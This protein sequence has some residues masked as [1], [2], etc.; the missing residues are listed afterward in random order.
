LDSPRFQPWGQNLEATKGFFI[1]EDWIAQG[2]NLR[3]RILE[4]AEG[5]LLEKIG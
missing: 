5:F 4:V 1:D 2:F 3:D